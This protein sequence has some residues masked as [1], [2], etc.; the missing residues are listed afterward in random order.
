MRVTTAFNK[1]LAIDDANVVSVTF[2]TDGVVVGLRHRRRRPTC[3]CGWRGRAVYDRS[4]RRWRHLDLGASKLFLEAEIRRLHCR[5]CD[6]VRTED[7]AWARPSARHTRDFEDVV[8]WL[9]QE[10]ARTPICGLLRVGWDTVGRIVER[11]TADRLDERR[12]EKLVWIGGSV[13]RSV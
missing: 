6:R 9:A 3:P 5:R 2:A 1:L 7:V 13:R 4:T 10:M 8:A 11:V 12:L